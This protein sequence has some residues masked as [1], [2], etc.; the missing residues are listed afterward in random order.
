MG[1]PPPLLLRNCEFP[2]NLYNK[3]R[4]TESGSK[5]KENTIHLRK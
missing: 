4:G 1:Q 3:G 5:A 2:E